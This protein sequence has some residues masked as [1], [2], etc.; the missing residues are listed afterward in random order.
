MPVHNYVKAGFK[1]HGTR[2]TRDIRRVTEQDGLFQTQQVRQGITSKQY[3][4][5]NKKQYT[6]IK[7]GRALFKKKVRFTLP[8]SKTYAPITAARLAT[9][10]TKLTKMRKEKDAKNKAAEKIKKQAFVDDFEQQQVH[11]FKQ[12]KPYM[13]PYDFLRSLPK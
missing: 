2:L 4:R 6:P 1:R 13:S 8:K 11:A 9:S 3:K 12:G 7:Q 10:K 5:K